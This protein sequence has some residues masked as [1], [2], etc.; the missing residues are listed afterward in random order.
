MQPELLHGLTFGKVAC[1]RSGQATNWSRAK[2]KLTTSTVMASVPDFLHTVLSPHDTTHILLQALLNSHCAFLHTPSLVT[3]SRVETRPE[4][5]IL[6]CSKTPL[7][8]A[9]PCKPTPRIHL[10]TASAVNVSP[11]HH[12]ASCSPTS[13][14]SHDALR[15]LPPCRRPWC[16]PRW[17]RPSHGRSSLCGSHCRRQLFH[18]NPPPKRARRGDF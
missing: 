18:L 1:C 2:G 5:R 9:T 10:S 14:P 16:R 4:E 6:P 11:H 7:H 3:Q 8:P 17:R 13:P 12:P 15:R